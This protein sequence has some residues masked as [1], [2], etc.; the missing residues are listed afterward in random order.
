MLKMFVLG[1][2]LPLES[3][4]IFAAVDS[5]CR[6]LPLGVGPQVNPAWKAVLALSSQGNGVFRP[7]KPLQVV[8]YHT[9]TWI[10]MPLVEPLGH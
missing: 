8:I 3:I 6:C 1:L 10:G 7:M 4:S 5:S 9:P 2:I